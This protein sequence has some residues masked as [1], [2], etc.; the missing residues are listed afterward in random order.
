MTQELDNLWIGSY[1]HCSN[2]MYDPNKKIQI[3][4]FLTYALV[5]SGFQHCLI[6]VAFLLMVGIP[7]EMVHGGLRY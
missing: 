5:H 4:R 6:N 1:P 2:L 7:L 3:W